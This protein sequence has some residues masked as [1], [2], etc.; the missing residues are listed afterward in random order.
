MCCRKTNVYCIILKLILR[1]DKEFRKTVEK[2][3]PGAETIIK[4]ALNEEPTVF[5]GLTEQFESVTKKFDDVSKTITGATTKVTGIF[6]SSKKDEK[7]G[8]YN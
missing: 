5:K 7:K 2:N 3:I 8:N 4:V 6:G 1:Y